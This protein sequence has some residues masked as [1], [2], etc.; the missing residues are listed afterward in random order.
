MKWETKLRI[1]ANGLGV[2]PQTRRGAKSP[3]FCRKLLMMIK[4]GTRNGELG[5]K[6]RRLKS[7]WLLYTLIHYTGGTLLAVICATQSCHLL[8]KTCSL[9]LPRRKDKRDS[10]E[11][12]RTVYSDA[13]NIKSHTGIDVSMITA[14]WSL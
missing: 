2:K 9:L 14:D 13:F 6:R 4:H 10:V 12:I 11:S 7:V 8:W 5:R 1:L 3:L